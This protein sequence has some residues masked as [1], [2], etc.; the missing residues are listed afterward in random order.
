MLQAA[1]D[2]ARQ[3]LSPPFRNVLLKSLGLTFVLL[4]LAWIGLD[5]AR[6]LFRHRRQLLVA[7]GRHFR[8]RRR[9]RRRPRLSHR[10]DL[11]TG[12]GLFPRRSRRVVEEE[13]DPDGPRGRP[14][15]AG[16][17]MVMALRFALVSA[18]VNLV[19]LLLLLVPGVNAI[20][21]VLANA[22]SVRPG[23]FRLRGDAL[24][25]A[26]GGPRAD[27]P[28]C[29]DLVP[30]GAVH[31]RLRRRAGAQ[32]AHAA[33]RRRLH[34]AAAQ[35]A[36]R[37]SGPRGGAGALTAARLRRAAAP[38]TGRSCD[39][40]RDRTGRSSRSPSARCPA[41]RSVSPVG[42][43]VGGDDIVVAQQLHL[44][45]RRRQQAREQAERQ[46]MQRL[47]DARHERRRSRRRAAGCLASRSVTFSTY[48]TSSRKVFTSGPPSS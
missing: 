24:L 10:A 12:R 6:A 31:R 48:S 23:I 32:S 38:D 21:F 37:P 2:A 3:I 28:P 33:V 34:G 41:L 22:Y 13:I 44:I 30:R 42:L 14:L 8:D 17:A 4:A 20:V 19:A 47:R 25:L 43:G 40:D 18:G 11:R 9:P 15:P 1:I 16:Q 46:R 39:S 26:G 7:H 45:D 27:A 29:D 35:A 5:K 36:R